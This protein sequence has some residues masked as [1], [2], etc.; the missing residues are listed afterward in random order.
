MNTLNLNSLITLLVICF[1]TLIQFVFKIEIMGS[2]VAITPSDFLLPITCFLIFSK[3]V[4]K[5]EIFFSS[6][7]KKIFIGIGALTVWIFFSLVNGMNYTG[8]FSN[9]GFFNKFIGWF[10]LLIYLLSG[11]ILGNVNEKFDDLFVKTIVI[12]CIILGL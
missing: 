1:A 6:Q 10:V 11:A 4:N 9:W 2:E 8:E 5:G 3:I 12:I 7:S